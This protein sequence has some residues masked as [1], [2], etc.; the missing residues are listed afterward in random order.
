MNINHER[1]AKIV[2]AITQRSVLLSTNTKNAH[3]PLH[4]QSKSVVHH[5]A[6]DIHLTSSFSSSFFVIK[7]SKTSFINNKPKIRHNGHDKKFIATAIVSGD[8]QLPEN[9]DPML[10]QNAMKEYH[11]Y[12]IDPAVHVFHR[13]NQ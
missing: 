9:T 13:N 10:N 2:I 1:M 8:S 5:V 4:N 12:G 7:K 11:K 6:K 3:I